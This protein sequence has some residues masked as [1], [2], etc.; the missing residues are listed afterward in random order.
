MEIRRCKKE[1]RRV[2][3]GLLLIVFLLPSWLLSG[4]GLNGDY[5][6]S[7]NQIRGNGLFLKDSR[8][9]QVIEYSYQDP[10]LSK[11]Y[12][13]T[14]GDTLVL[15]HEPETNI[16]K[17]SY[18]PFEIEQCN[19]GS[20]ILPQYDGFREYRFRLKNT[21]D[22]PVSKLQVKFF[23]RDGYMF[24]RVMDQ[25]GELSVIT[26]EKSVAKILIMLMGYDFLEIMPGNNDTYC[27]GYEVT[28]HPAMNSRTKTEVTLEK[29]LIVKEDQKII[30]LKPLDSTRIWL[31]G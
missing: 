8:F 17:S 15:V 21:E 4:Q 12:Y 2:V 22:L 31:K 11:G 16:L 25:N 3:K 9:K 10:Y 24:G 6:D 28:I 13:L 19:F 30:G 18:T 5:F 29:F 14:I 27:L 26:G 20:G 7:S 1:K 23:G